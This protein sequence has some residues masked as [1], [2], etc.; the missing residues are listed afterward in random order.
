ML[1]LEILTEPGKYFV[2]SIFIGLNNPVSYHQ[3]ISVLQRLV[4]L[5]PVHV[6]AGNIAIIMGLRKYKSLSKSLPLTLV[7]L[8]FECFAFLTTSKVG[9]GV[10]YYNPFILFSSVLIQITLYS[11]WQQKAPSLP[12]KYGI[13][14]A[15]LAVSGTFIFR[16]AYHYTSPFLKYATSKAEYEHRW[17][18]I[19]KVCKEIH[20][21][22]QDKILVLDPLTRIMLATNTIM[23][24]L[25]YYMVSPF[26]YSNFIGNEEK[27]IDYLIFQSSSAGTMDDCMK[28][29]NINPTTY[30]LRETKSEYTIL[31]KR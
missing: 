27:G 24:N 5:Y 2:K 21:K 29:F 3:F 11:L 9:S 13:L 4:E 22:L 30:M 6:I 28:F 26:D 23:P 12:L 20:L 10:S 15:V 16:Q 19:E 25:E 7:T 8:F 17:T 1:I 14:L 18:E 31:A